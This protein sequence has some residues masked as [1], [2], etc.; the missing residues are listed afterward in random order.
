MAKSSQTKEMIIGLTQ[1]GATS[2]ID[3]LF[4]LIVN[5]APK[6]VGAEE[7]SIFW[8]N[9]PWREKDIEN[10][11]LGSPDDFY[12]RAFTKESKLLKSK[13]FYKPGEGLTGW[14]AKTGIALNVNDIFSDELLAIGNNIKWRDEFPQYRD[15]NKQKHQIAFLSLPVKIQDEVMGVIRIVKVVELSGKIKESGQVL[16]ETFAKYVSTIIVQI[17]EQKEKD[18]WEKLYLSGVSF[19]RKEFAKY[20]Q[21]VADEIPQSLSAKGC[22]IFLSEAAPDGGTI[23]KLRF[24]TKLGPLT[25]EVGKAYYKSGE[26]LTGWVAKHNK[27]LLIKDV[28]DKKELEKIDL[29]L[30]HKGKHEE[31]VK[32]NSSFLAAPI[33][34]GGNV[35]GVIRI[36]KEN[37]GRFFSS[38]DE[39]FLKNFCDKLA[40]LV[41]N[42]VLFTNLQTERDSASKDLEKSRNQIELLGKK[43]KNEVKE[44]Q[45]FLSKVFPLEKEEGHITIGSQD[46][47]IPKLNPKM[48]FIGIPFSASSKNVY[49]FGILPA[50]N[51][52]N[53]EPWIADERTDSLRILGNI[54]EGVLQSSIGIF[55]ITKLNPNV[56]FELGLMTGLKK[57]AILL[58]Q[59]DSEIPTDLSDWIY[60]S[61]G[62]FGKLQ[63]DLKRHIPALLSLDCGTKS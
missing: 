39:R 46:I 27:S 40:V 19:E 61:Y 36:A 57:Q 20:L 10:N 59:E 8:K 51:D 45:L 24:T 44:M 11:D 47:K 52:L 12:K 29:E 54:L 5:E 63:E 41:E 15:L 56:L 7:C 60:I 43:F 9:G 33:S 22:S 37:E 17:E 62:S 23:F 14:V 31:Y 55:D 18:S 28:D 16:L 3:K 6:L 50:L 4:E 48:V 2:D 32:K 58:K 38:S 25:K 13:T 30:N 26:G 34:R 21:R 49:D 42:N 1:I 53:L 35:K